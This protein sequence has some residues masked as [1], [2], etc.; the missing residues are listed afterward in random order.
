VG[1]FFFS[2]FPLSFPVFGLFSFPLWFATCR[3]AQTA[4]EIPGEKMR[5]YSL[6]RHMRV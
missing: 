1:Y 4:D 2:F 3:L 6:D 5:R